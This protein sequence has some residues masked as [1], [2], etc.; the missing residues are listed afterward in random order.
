MHRASCQHRHIQC[1]LYR[2]YS[3]HREKLRVLLPS[4]LDALQAL[5]NAEGLKV[6]NVKTEMS[7]WPVTSFKRL[8]AE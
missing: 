4:I 7:M 6:I 8:L 1:S 3:V 5:Q 2:W